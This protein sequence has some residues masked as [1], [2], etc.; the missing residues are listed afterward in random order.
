MPVPALTRWLAASAV[1]LAGCAGLPEPLPRAAEPALPAAD[2]PLARIAAA[3][4][5]A[6]APGQS[7]FRLLFD[8]KPAFNARIA[9]V[10]RATRSLD[11]QVYQFAADQTGLGLL[12][13]L[14]DAAQR[15]VRVRLLIDDLHAGGMD[16]LL[17][18]LSATPNAQVRLFNPLPVRDGSVGLRLLRSLHEFARI[19]RRM[20]NKLL[21]ADGSLAIFG[22]RNMVDG[23]F[24]NDPQANFL[25]LDL[26]AAGPVVSQ[27]SAAFEAFWSSAHAYPVEQLAVP[28]LAADEARRRFDA[29][30]QEGTVRLGERQR[31]WFGRPGVL[32]ELAQGR[33]T[34]DSATAQVLADAP[35]KV[36]ASAADRRPTS[37][38]EQA[39]ALLAA[40]SD[41]ALLM[42]PY[43]IPGV[44][45]LQ[46]LQALHERKVPVALLTNSVAATDEPLAY[47]GYERYRLELLR[48]GVGIYELSPTL[49]RD[50]G[51]VA[52][53]GDTIGRLHTKLLVIDRRRLIVG[54]V[55][56][57]P[58]SIHLNTELAV[59]IDS[60]ELAQ[61]IARIFRF[62]IASGAYRLRRVDERIEWIE[63]DWQGR[64][65]VHADEP[66]DDP[67]L[68]FKLWLLRPLVSEELL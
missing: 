39:L 35:D 29:A 5:P 63:T 14:R 55:N 40:A 45:G 1:A 59:L 53:F 67:W 37:V 24:M 36:D 25:D 66:G 20:H 54:S 16:A 60:P 43:F 21:L 41:D 33:L 48:A 6:D 32:R 49:A 9:L 61:R 52:Y 28:A 44:H 34:L 22:G 50:S 58:R 42:S 31:D 7:G 64:E 27:L 56:L 57:D 4:L 30:V 51:R 13:E 23:Y 65:T 11:L 18:G 17:A 12:R 68:R 62:G 47:A 8:G 38:A 46:V 3:S 15:G 2:A 10:R 19:N 26:L